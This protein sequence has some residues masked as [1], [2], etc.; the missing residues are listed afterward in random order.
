LLRGLRPK[1]NRGLIPFAKSIRH[2]HIDINAQFYLDG[3]A[4]GIEAVTRKYVGTIS[5]G[6]APRITAALAK[7]ARLW[8]PHAWSV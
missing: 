7:R 6:R 5:I 3:L 2:K 4:Q 8:V 1:H